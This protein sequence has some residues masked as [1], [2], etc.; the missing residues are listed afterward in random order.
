M[1]KARVHKARE[2][3]KAFE[4]AAIHEAK[5]QNVDGIIYCNDGDWIESC[6]A[7]VEQQDGKIEL[8]HW[9]DTQTVLDSADITKLNISTD[10]K[11]KKS[12]A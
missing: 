6:T 11:P 3:I 4:N 1:I 8:L 9:S 10:A 5:K 12:A 2:A 7:L